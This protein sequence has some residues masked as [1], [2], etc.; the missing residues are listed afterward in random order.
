MI[1]A[2]NSGPQHHGVK[3][4][5]WQ[6]R[7]STKFDMLYQS[8]T[9]ATNGSLISFSLN[10]KQKETIGMLIGGNETFCL[11]RTGFGKSSI[12]DQ[13]RVPLLNITIL[14]TLSFKPMNFFLKNRIIISQNKEFNSLVHTYA[15]FCLKVPSD[16][17]MIYHIMSCQKR[18]YRQ[19]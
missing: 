17:L 2:G 16:T 15:Y 3:A 19:N 4:C 13:N 10:V 8:I 14:C 5:S 18:A 11:L 12:F 9:F 7:C 6:E 1:P